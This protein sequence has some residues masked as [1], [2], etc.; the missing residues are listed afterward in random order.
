M[1]FEMPRRDEL[2]LGLQTTIDKKVQA[3]TA[4]GLGLK[5][6][7]GSRGQ[8]VDAHFQI[9]FPLKIFLLFKKRFSISR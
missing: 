9:S 4:V 2:T 1:N 8:E 3:F 5:E 6:R 7:G